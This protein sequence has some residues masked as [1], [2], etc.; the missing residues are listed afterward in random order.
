MST[1]PQAFVA[2]TARD[3]RLA[4][5]IATGVAKANARTKT[6][7]YTPW[8]FNDIAG[9]PLIS[10]ILEGIESSE[11]VVADITYL[12]PNVVYE[13]GFAIGSQKRVFLLRNRLED[14]DKKIAQ[15]AGIF[16]TLGY[17][18]YEDDDGLAHK[19]SSYI[20]TNPQPLPTGLDRLAPVYVVEPLEKG[21]IATLMTS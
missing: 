17:E 5:M 16:D 8:E 6:I 7:R 18:E 1:T 3:P 20:D 11:F 10:P 21:G 15:T 19:L 9:H 4:A 13:V 2:Y 12:N 14:G